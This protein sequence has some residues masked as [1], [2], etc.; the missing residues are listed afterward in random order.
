MKIISSLMLL[1]MLPVLI[2]AQEPTDSITVFMI[3]DSTMANKPLKDENQERGWGQMLP[4]MLQGKI[5]VDNHAVNGRSSRSF[6]NEGRWDKVIELIRPGDYLV[7]EFGHNDE[8]PGEKRHTDPG[9]TFDDN[10]R[11]F[12]QK[13][14]EKGATPILMNSIV[15]RNFPANIAEK[16]EDRDDNPPS[17]TGPTKNAVEGDI[18]VD[19]HGAYLISPRTV[20]EELGTPFV[21]LNALTHCLVQSLGREKSKELFMWIPANTYKFCPD[22]KIDNTH[23][24]IYGGKV[25]AAIA[26]KAI[27]EAVP[28]LKP[29]IKPGILSL[30]DIK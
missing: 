9:S 22:G 25:V 13:A 20:A 29:Y 28:G 10:L 30:P 4:M 3:G 21:D 16:A 7:I 2:M 11:M 26:A 14:L 24:N 1:V 15:R 8:K 23:L 5:R 27:A 19:T 12:A 17:A 6:I 18:L